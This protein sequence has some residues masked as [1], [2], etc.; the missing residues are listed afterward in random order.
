[1]AP[2]EG[3]PENI[4]SMIHLVYIC[5]LEISHLEMEKESL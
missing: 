1:M 4:A 2:F 5:E 3:I